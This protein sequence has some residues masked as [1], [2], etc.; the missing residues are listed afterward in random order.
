M[1][2]DK[3]KIISDAK[4]LL[5]KAKKGN[6]WVAPNGM[7]Q[8]PIVVGNAVV[9]KLWKDVDLNELEIGAH[10][11]AKFGVNVELVKNGEVA[12]VLWLAL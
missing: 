3:E 9:G 11:I 5:A 8:V 7:V 2:V 10:W 12:G 1:N 6:K 4:E